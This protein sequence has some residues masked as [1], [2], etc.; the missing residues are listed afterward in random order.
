[1]PGP[2]TALT[3]GGMTTT[4]TTS[5]TAGDQGELRIVVGVD[6]SPCAGRALEFAA[7]EAARWGALLH[8]VAAYEIPPSASWI[9]VPL[10]PLQEGAADS[11]SEA[12]ARVHELE[13]GVVTKG[14]H[15]Y[16]F[17]G[18]VLVDRSAGASLL[19]VGTRGHGEVASLVLGSVSA[20]CVHHAGG[21]PVT[22]VG[23]SAP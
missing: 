2:A 21:C 19:V 12:L 15:V 1:M 14:E 8:I 6:G 23:V 13:P 16:G 22:V 18:S 11:V 20:H 5:D 3:M 9:V 17:A 4:A 10:E 7:H